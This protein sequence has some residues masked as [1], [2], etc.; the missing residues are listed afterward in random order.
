MFDPCTSSA[1]EFYKGA[2][3]TFTS[4]DLTGLWNFKSLGY[5]PSC[6]KYLEWFL[7][8]AIPWLVLIHTL[9]VGTSLVA[10]TVKH[11]PTI[12]DT[13]VQSLGREDPLEKEMAIHSSGLAW[14]IPWMEECG[15]LPSM[16]LERVGHYWTTSLSL[17]TTCGSAEGLI[18][19]FYLSIT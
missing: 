8:L 1:P 2:S 11:L 17:S 5:I 3:V 10:Q 14:K 13:Q 4:P 19:T 6:L 9:L 12:R 15:R 18:C 16:G 7:S